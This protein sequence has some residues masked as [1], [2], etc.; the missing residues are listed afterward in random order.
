MAHRVAVHDS[1][2]AGHPWLETATEFCLGAIDRRSSAPHAIELMYILHLLD[3][4]ADSRPRAQ[5]L[6]E[7]VAA[8]HLPRDG[9]VHVDGG[10]DDEFLRPLDYS[11]RPNRPLRALI[12]PDAIAADLDRW[13]SLRQDDG[14]WVVDFASSSDIAA[15]EWRGYATVRAITLLRDNGR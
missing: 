3:G 10:L 12:D 5:E 2:V 13:H 9:T 4:L 11:P 15:L 6:L 1:A 8:A 7:R 14:G